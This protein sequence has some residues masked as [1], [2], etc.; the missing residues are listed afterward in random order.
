[1]GGFFIVNDKYKEVTPEKTISKIRGILAD[2]NI[3]PIETHWFDSAQDF[4]SVRISIPDTDLGTNGKGTTRVY[5]LASAYA[6]L[7]ERLQNMSPFKLSINLERDAYEKEGFCFLPDEQEITIDEFIESNNQW[8]EEQIKNTDLEKNKEKLKNIVKQWK[9]ITYNQEKE[10]FNGT[11]LVN[12]ET[13][14]KSYVPQI[15]LSKMYMSNGMCAGNK[16][17]EAINQG[18][19]ETMERYVNRKIIKEKITPPDI[20]IDYLM[21]YPKI[22]R[23]IKTIQDK[24]PYNLMIKD[25]SLGEKLPVVGAILHNTEEQTYFVKFGSF[26]DFDIAAERTLTELLQGQNITKMKGMTNFV[27]ENNS[28]N[29]DNIIGILVNGVGNYPLELFEST[30][31]YEFDPDVFQKF[32]DNKQILDYYKDLLSKNGKKILIRDVANLGFPAYQV[33]IP[34]FSEIE[35]FEN[36]KSI[37][38]YVNF[39]KVKGMMVKLDKLNKDEKKYLVDLL[40]NNFNINS[41]PAKMIG[42]LGTENYPWYYE[43]MGLLQVLLYCQIGDHVSAYYKNYQWLKIYGFNPKFENLREIQFA[44]NNYLKMK[45]DNKNE[46]EIDKFMKKYYSSSLIDELM[47]KYGTENGAFQI[48]SPVQCFDCESCIYNKKCKKKNNQ[49]VYL[50]LK[51]SFIQ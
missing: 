45:V 24:G 41:I 7:L 26:I 20:P 38:K 11:P 33:I 31:S 15:M 50:R 3:M 48:N 14:E 36:E 43:N 22:I 25:C 9:Q 5:A 34:K 17:E 21:K 40:E 1:M 18:I 47:T 35:E 2:I 46:E 39:I 13:N 10:K 23:M 28:D 37:N 30:P 51:K 29:N 19:S 44:L 32:D 12:L 16:K 6:E 49:E 8:L 4:Y 42:I 27:C